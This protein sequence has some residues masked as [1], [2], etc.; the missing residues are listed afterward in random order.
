[1]FRLRRRL[2]TW[3]ALTIALPLAARALRHAS[4]AIESRHGPTPNS[5][6]L[7]RLADLAG[8]PPKRRARRR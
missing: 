3:A 5:A 7:R 6:R 8:Q 2:T 4:G 1:M